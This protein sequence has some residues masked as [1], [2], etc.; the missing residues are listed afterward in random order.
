M[1]H[2]TISVLAGTYDLLMCLGALLSTHVSDEAFTEIIRITK[3][4]MTFCTKGV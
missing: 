4:G 1:D 3:P 2:F